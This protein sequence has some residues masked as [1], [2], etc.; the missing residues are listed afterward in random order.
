M[1][2]R[3]NKALDIIYEYG[4]IDG[5]HHQ[6]W[7][8]DQILRTLLGNAYGPWVDEY[9]EGGEYEWDIGVAP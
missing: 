5:D 4:G 8:V 2:D 9:E 3:V 1:E 7:I 6:K